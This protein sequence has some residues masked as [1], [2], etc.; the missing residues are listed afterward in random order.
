MQHILVV[1]GLR[2]GGDG[3]QS[4]QKYSVAGRS[5]V[6]VDLLRIVLSAV[7][8]RHK[9]LGEPNRGLDEDEDVCYQAEDGMR[10]LEVGAVMLELGHHDDDESGEERRD[11]D[12]D[13]SGVS[14]RPVSLLL[15]R[16]RWL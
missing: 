2:R 11:A 7:D 3:D 5:V 12:V 14:I 10:R 13:E 15:G 6:L 16:M 8:L 1:I 9:V 4:Q